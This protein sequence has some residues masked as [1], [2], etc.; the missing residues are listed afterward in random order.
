LPGCALVAGATGLVG[1]QLVAALPAGFH[2][3]PSD[4]IQAFAPD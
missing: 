3:V 1:S 2:D 4:V